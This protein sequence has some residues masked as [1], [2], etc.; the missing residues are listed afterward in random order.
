M[1][2]SYK[3]IQAARL[4]K[5]ME[6]RKSWPFWV[7]LIAAVAAGLAG[8]VEF[9]A[10]G[11][12]SLAREAVRRQEVSGALRHYARA[13]SWYV[14][15]GSAETAAAELLELGLRLKAEG[16]YEPAF[17][18]FSRMRAGLYGAR[19]LYTPRPD[20][21]ARAEPPLAELMA[22]RKLG[23]EASASD[24]QVQSRR[25]LDLLARP[26]KPN[27]APG[28]AAAGGF[29][30]WVGAVLVFV[31]RFSRGGRRLPW[32]LLWAA[33]FALWLWGLWLT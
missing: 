14:P 19:G 31:V 32:L 27:L 25:Y 29:L 18:A 21:I 9:R 2:R 12:L 26:A 8:L 17:L 11:E 28:L 33:G 16:R 30:L 3:R 10:R 1:L 20:L 24:L 23:P 6:R 4:E 7:I 13:L 5:V 22:R 15:W